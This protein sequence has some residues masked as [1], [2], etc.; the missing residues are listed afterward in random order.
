MTILAVINCKVLSD[1]QEY[2]LILQAQP[3]VINN[4]YISKTN[5]MNLKFPFRDIPYTP[6]EEN[7]NIS[8]QG[9]LYE[10]NKEEN[11]KFFYI[12]NFL[13]LLNC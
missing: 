10:I 9:L 3:Y 6:R 1:S 5:F 13:I 8:L 12:R 2:D 7:E 11:V 4:T